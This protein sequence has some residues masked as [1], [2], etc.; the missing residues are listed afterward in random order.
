MSFFSLLKI[1]LFLIKFLHCVPAVKILKLLKFISKI[2]NYHFSKLIKKNQV[3]LELD[4]TK[5]LK[6]LVVNQ[7]ILF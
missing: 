2:Q 3:L 6:G 4:Q 1:N 7:V 5:F